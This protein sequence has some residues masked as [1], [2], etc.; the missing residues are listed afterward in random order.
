MRIFLLLLGVLCLWFPALSQ[1]DL[2]Q[3]TDADGVIHIVDETSAVPD[4]YRA[5]MKVYRAAKPTPGV[6]P[7]P[8]SPSRTYAAQSQGAFAQKLALDLGLIK[9]S[10]EDAFG[11]L[12]GAG[13]QP[14]SGW[15]ANDPLTP[16]VLDDVLAA[17]RRAAEAQRLRLSADGAEAVV[18]QAGEAFLPPSTPDSR[19]AWAEGEDGPEY[20]QQPQPIIIEQ[21]QNFEVEGEPDYG[22]IPFI[23]GF[24]GRHHHHGHHPDDHPGSPSPPL[25]G[26]FTPNPAGVPGSPT[27]LPF[28]TSHLPFESSRVR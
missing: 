7:L 25:N 11:P 2:Y 5:G 24:P 17:A 4:T 21:P 1:A 3:W 18:R 8:V 10:S 22:D 9:M 15:E 12:R 14:A 26:P 23:F 19:P 20:V 6:S 16:E 27:H 28:G 13:V